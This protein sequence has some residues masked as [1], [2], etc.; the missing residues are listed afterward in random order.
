MG[1]EISEIVFS[2]FRWANNDGTVSAT[3]VAAKN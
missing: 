2:Q 1:Y 3:S